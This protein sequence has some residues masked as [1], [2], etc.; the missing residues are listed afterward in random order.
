M[1]IPR[2][3][4]QTWKTREIPAL[5]ASAQESWPALHPGWEYRFWTDQDLLDLVAGRAPE[6][7]ALFRAYPD[8]IQR[9]DA[10]RYLILREIGGVYVDLDI[11]CL[12]PLD[13]FLPGGGVLLAPTTPLGVSNDF[14]LAEPGHPLFRLAVES[15]E[16][17]F[18]R[19]SH[20]WVPRHF[21]ILLTTGSLFLTR[22]AR[23]QGEETGVRLLTRGQYGHG[24]REE[25]LVEHLPGNSWAGWDTRL[26][27]ALDRWAVEPVLKRVRRGAARARR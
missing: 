16:G 15:L 6:L 22:C 27:V 2:I 12:R 26:F 25:A 9:V 18:R 4:H 10:A 1:S 3:I 19:W 8:S 17:S 5:W 21:R 14:M 20:P 23:G 11:A 7:L 24:S 13:P